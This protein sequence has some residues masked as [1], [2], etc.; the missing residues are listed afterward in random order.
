MK[1]SQFTTGDFIEDTEF[2][3]WV[4][5]PTTESAAFWEDF[6]LQHPE[7]KQ[8]IIVARNV[9]LT[10]EAQVESGFSTKANE[11]RVFQQIQQQI[12]EKQEVTI[13][14]LPVWVRWAA[15]AC[16]VLAMSWWLID[17]QTST[18]EV[19]Y[20]VNRKQSESPLV[21][22]VNDTAKP[23]LVT[24]ADG[25]SIFL[26]PK[27]RI[28]Y[29]KTFNEG[30]KREVYLSGEAFFEVAKNPTKPFFVYA[31]ELVTKV[32]GTSF[33]VRA[34]PEDKNVIVKVRT[35]RVAV[36]VAKKI[37]GQQSISTRE[38]EGIVLLP[39]QQAVLSRQEIR[40]VK[41][42]VENPTLLSVT[43]P[44]PMRYSF[45]FEAARASDVFNM[46]EK[47]YGIDIVFDEEVFSKCQFTADLTDES[48]YEKL[49]IICK[50]IEANYQVLD[51][52]V[53][54]SGKGCAN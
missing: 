49:D 19:T 18:V 34:F 23:I 38:V 15:A 54:I 29:S 2:R 13:R 21:E 33:N 8:D 53:I 32:L 31:N 9:L 14:R 1:Y 12:G 42:L 20:E 26:N 36:T 35:G 6:M 27:S 28:S 43:T 50:S 22:K 11:D 16:F 44:T 30:S 4:Q 10:L 47:A 24:L 52:Q 37:S 41:S 46:I 7:K 25:S 3:R 39:N 5:Q 48:L 51:A 40:L 17:K 45:V